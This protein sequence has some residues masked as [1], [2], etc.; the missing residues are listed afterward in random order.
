MRD[1]QGLIGSYDRLAAAY[2]DRLS[3]ELADK[4]FDRSLLARLVESA[5]SSRL[6]DAGCGPGHVTAQ[7]VE[8][9]AAT[10]RIDLSSGR[11]DE[12]R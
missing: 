9:G 2:A 6:C 3:S 5:Q 10:R 7:L 8:L 4:P 12:A 1:R 11:V